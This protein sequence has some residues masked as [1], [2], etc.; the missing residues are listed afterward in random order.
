MRAGANKTPGQCLQNWQIIKKE[1][2]DEMKTLKPP[3]FFYKEKNI[4]KESWARN[5]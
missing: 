2:N 5:L 3:Q 1:I 4:C